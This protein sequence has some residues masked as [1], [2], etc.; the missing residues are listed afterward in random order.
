MLGLAVA[1]AVVL[2]PITRATPQF[3]SPSA[4]A[5]P[6]EPAYTEGVASWYGD[7][8]HG[9]PTANGEVYD[10]N[11]LT[12]AH[13]DLPIG[14]WVRVTNIRTKRTVVLRINDRGPWIP[15]RMLDVSKAA[16]R[17]LGFMGSGLATVRMEVTE[18]PRKRTRVRAA[19]P[20]MVSSAMP[21]SVLADRH[22]ERQ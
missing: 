17:S 16:A 15:G 6:S 5:S 21:V 9:K 4:E 2:L 19:G 11:G 10:M 1:S 20:V 13:K 7:D 3:S 14:T 22:A 12:A 8:F 18:D